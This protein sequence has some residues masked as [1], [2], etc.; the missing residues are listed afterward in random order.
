MQLK[1]V[2]FSK[3]LLTDMCRLRSWLDKGLGV[4]Q[5]VISMLQ[6]RHAERYPEVPEVLKRMEMQNCKHCW[7]TV[8]QWTNTTWGPAEWYSTICL[9]IR[10]KEWKDTD[11]WQKVSMLLRKRQTQNSKNA[12]NAPGG[13][14]NNGFCTL[15]FSRFRDGFIFKNEM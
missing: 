7:K 9:H 13:V 11:V 6:T 5:L 10:R 8:L 1:P 12:W 3:R 4:R 14:N 2:Y 15:L